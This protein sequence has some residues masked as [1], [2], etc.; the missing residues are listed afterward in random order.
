[1]WG[2]VASWG[3]SLL[4]KPKV[5]IGLAVALA[6]AGTIGVYQVKLWGA[7]SERDTAQMEAAQA[8]EK[9]AKAE[10]SLAVMT[11]N[12]DLLVSTVEA[13][14]TAVQQMERQARQMEG[15][16]TAAALR[17]LQGGAK[18]QQTI[19]AASAAGPE[20]MNKWLAETFSR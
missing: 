7:R 8:R 13:Q 10:K 18:R 11:A 20:E 2:M 19:S 17:A 16:A 6:F 1:M 3:M 9:Q 12:R 5:L 4:G 14:N 15:A